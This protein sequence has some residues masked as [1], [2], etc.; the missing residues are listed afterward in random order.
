MFSVLNLPLVRLLPQS[1]LAK[2]WR[3]RIAMHQNRID[4]SEMP[5]GLQRD[6]GLMDGRNPRH[7]SD[8]GAFRAA[9]LIHAHRSL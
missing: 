4:M 5:E 6:L 9:R 1:G 8:E 7:P 3:R 2:L